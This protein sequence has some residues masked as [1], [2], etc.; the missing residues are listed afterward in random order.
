MEIKSYK[1]IG[2]VGAGQMGSG[3]A[4]VCAMS[5][6]KVFLSDINKDVLDR[7]QSTIQNSLQKLTQKELIS[8]E[9]AQK[10]SQA[11]TYTT[12][13]QEFEP[14]DL[15]IEA[16]HEN[17]SL[18]GQ[19]L[20]NLDRILAKDA[21]LA[22]NTSSISITKLAHFTSRPDRFVGI[23]FMNP[24]PL[25]KLV[26][27]I[28]GLKTDPQVLKRTLKF[29]ETLGK[30]T[31]QSQDYPG[32]IVNR[33]LMPMINEAFEA[34]KE[35]IASA[36]D[37]D[38]GMKLGTNQPMGP[39][40]LA[41]FIGLD[42]CLSVLEVMHQGLGD[43]KYRPSPLLRKYVDGGLLGRKVKQGVYSYE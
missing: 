35:G 43:P 23:H 26:E 22:S 41:D 9:I 11:L 12:Q 39:L 19:I 38:R 21:V 1:W 14:C 42:T 17:I 18:K 34:L 32:F 13:I 2:V 4:Q 36:E 7:A 5:G 25:M 30:E 20:K 24:V 10:A 27:V 8:A 16:V 15:V 37:I 31:V 28:V 33:I 3:I 29:C 40:A 6:Y